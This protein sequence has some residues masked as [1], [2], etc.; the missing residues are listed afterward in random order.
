MPES[1]NS[2]KLGLTLQGV[3]PP[4]RFQQQVRDLEAAG[5]SHLWVT[6]SS[7]HARYV[8]AYL[9]L[10]ALNS[11]H[12]LLGTGVTHPYTRHPGITVNAI[13]TID[14]IS[15]GRAMLGLGAGDRPTG[16][17]GFSP[18]RLHV[19]REMITTARRLLAGEKLNYTGSTFKLVEA[20]IHYKQRERVPIYMACSGPRMLALAGELADGIIVQVGVF[21]AAI[22]YALQRIA[23]GAGRAGRAVEDIELWVMAC[24]TISE[25]RDQA[26]HSS[27]LMAAWFAQT[28]PATCELAGLDPAIVSRIQAAYRGGEFHLAKDAAAL[29]PDEMVELF[30]VGGSPA[31]ARARIE[32]LAGFNI[33]GINFMPIG[34]NRTTSFKLFA[35]QMGIDNIR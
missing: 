26:R 30:T 23:E 2:F 32:R 29:V 1:S 31:E 21:P 4:D 7:L 3:E 11:Q 16:E 9:T 20:E 10:A 22:E 24:G 5:Y 17:L 8:Y 33:T 27:R 34:P 18:A 19:M 25:D 14:E 28:A 13:A 6:D 35:E 12:L 15:G